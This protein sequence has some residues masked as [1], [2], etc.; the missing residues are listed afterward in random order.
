[1]A[2]VTL[3]DIRQSIGATGASLGSVD[4]GGMSILS[5]HWPRGFDVTDMLRAAC[6]DLLCPVPHFFVVTKG[7]IRIRYTDDQTEEEARPGQV[8]YLRPGHTCWA[9]EDLEMV[10]ISPADGNNFLL[11]RIAATGLLG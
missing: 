4:H 9:T 7:A 1:M 5:H 10:E 3:A 6:G 2:V 8:A 11:G